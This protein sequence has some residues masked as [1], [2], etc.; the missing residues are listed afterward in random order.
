LGEKRFLSR[1]SL[2]FL[3]AGQAGSATKDAQAVHHHPGRPLA[4]D[5]GVVIRRV[6]GAAF[7]RS[8]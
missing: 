5:L 4:V 6:V 3:A 8:L 1:T 7:T 2:K